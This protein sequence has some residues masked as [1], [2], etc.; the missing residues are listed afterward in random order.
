MLGH[1]LVVGDVDEQVLLLEGLD[2]A[3][4]HSGDDLEGRGRDGDLGDEDAGHEVVGVHVLAEG[5][6]LLDA[7]GLVVG[8]FH[9]NGPDGRGSG[10]GEGVLFDHE[11]GGVGLEGEF[12][13]SFFH[14]LGCCFGCGFQQDGC[15]P[16]TSGHYRCNIE[17]ESLLAIYGLRLLIVRSP[18]QAQSVSKMLVDSQ[19]Q[20]LCPGTFR[21][22]CAMPA[23]GGLARAQSQGRFFCR[24]DPWPT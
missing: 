6:H 22:L 15:R 13:A 11:R 2:H 16:L 4:Q 21:V 1:E 5:P 14:V 24:Q 12:A 9:P 3:R 18:R 19:A 10:V 7:D 20:S 23:R 8:E 17:R